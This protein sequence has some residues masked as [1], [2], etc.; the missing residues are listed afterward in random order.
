M[1]DSNK[2]FLKYNYFLLFVKKL[3]I[4]EKTFYKKCLFFCI[5]LTNQSKSIMFLLCILL[6]AILFDYI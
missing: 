6:S 3:I 1:N 2:T 4:C 5:P